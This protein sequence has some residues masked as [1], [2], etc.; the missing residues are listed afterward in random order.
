MRLTLRSVREQAAAATA[1]AFLV[2]EETTAADDLGYCR[3]NHLVPAFVP[4]GDAFEHVPRKDR[5][6]LG[7]IVIK[8]HETAATD[9]ITVKR[10]Q[11][12]FH[13]NGINGL[14]LI[15]RAFAVVSEKN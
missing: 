2:S 1:L 14:Q 3:R 10:L 15:V 11:V 9:Q 7:I 5:Q 13:L 12:G 6:I 8:L 4:G